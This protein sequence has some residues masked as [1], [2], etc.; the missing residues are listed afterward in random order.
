MQASLYTDVKVVLYFVKGIICGWE[1]LRAF[2]A[3]VW[4]I[5]L[6][7][8]ALA[9]GARGEVDEEVYEELSALTFLTS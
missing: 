6:L 9:L 1:M 2:S 8:L 7:L 4:A 5:Y 3:V